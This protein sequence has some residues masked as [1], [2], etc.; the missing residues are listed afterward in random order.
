MKSMNTHLIIISLPFNRSTQCFQYN[1]YC[2]R[3]QIMFLL[4]LLFLLGGLTACLGTH[5]KE[6]ENT[7]GD[8]LHRPQISDWRG[9]YTFF[10]FIP[11]EEK[12]WA[13]ARVRYCNLWKILVVGDECG[14]RPLTF[15]DAVQ[16]VSKDKLILFQLDYDACDKVDQETINLLTATKPE[17]F[18][19]LGIRIVQGPK[20]NQLT[21]FETQCVIP[22]LKDRTIIMFD[23][24]P[25]D[26][27][28]PATGYTETMIRDLVSLYNS[29]GVD[30]LCFDSVYLE[31]ADRSQVIKYVLPTRV[32]VYDLEG[33][34]LSPIGMY[35]WGGIYGFIQNHSTPAHKV[36]DENFLIRV[37]SSNV[38]FDWLQRPADT[39]NEFVNPAAFLE[40]LE[41]RKPYIQ[42]DVHTTQMKQLTVNEKRTDN[43]LVSSNLVG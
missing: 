21:Q 22:A 18:F 34:A 8:K 35:S 28:G 5:L 23:E 40:Y 7:F 42:L 4:N 2:L 43:L 20:S 1:F 11:K 16:L 15:Y 38:F 33:H 9:A 3:L 30:S 29:T 39:I 41:Q 27:D 10:K 14:T 19:L 24:Y 25:K 31:A 6:L 26:D 36:L 12:N 32:S 37:T 17:K 13:T